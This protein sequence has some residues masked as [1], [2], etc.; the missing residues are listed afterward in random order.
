MFNSL[1]RLFTSSE[2][3]KLAAFQAADK[4]WQSTEGAGR[5]RELARLLSSSVHQ[6]IHLYLQHASS[7]DLSN[8]VEDL[9][10][11]V[12]LCTVRWRRENLETAPG[13]MSEEYHLRVSMALN[14]VCF[15][16]APTYQIHQSG[17]FARLARGIAL[18]EIH[19][20]DAPRYRMAFS[21]WDEHRATCALYAATLPLQ[22]PRIPHEP[23]LETPQ[24]QPERA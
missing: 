21:D 16:F 18:I 1:R 23:S 22:P 10:R 2:Q 3:A 17:S 7:T 24:A 11:A 12:Q 4:E 14:P 20:P 9:N 15:L 6:A 5:Q 13:L 19:D 8:H